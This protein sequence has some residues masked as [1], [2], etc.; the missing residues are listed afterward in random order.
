M[1]Y[2]NK[3]SLEKNSRESQLPYTPDE[4]QPMMECFLNTFARRFDNKLEVLRGKPSADCQ[5]SV[6]FSN[7]TEF[8]SYLTLLVK[9]VDSLD[10]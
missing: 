2:I 5:L 9:M 3:C 6:A 7:P 4:A 8:N 10:T 1:F